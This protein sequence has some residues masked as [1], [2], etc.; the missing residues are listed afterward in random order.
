[1]R[2]L[3]GGTDKGRQRKANQDAFICGKISD[4][5]VYCVL[6]D[7]MGG[8]NGGGIASETAISYVSGA[9]ARELKEGMSELSVKSVLESA[10]A[11]ANALIYEHA[12]Q[13]KSLSGMGTTMIIAV[14]ESNNVYIAFV[15]DSRVYISSGNACRQVTKDHTVVQMLVDIGEISEEDA[16][17]H[18][19]RHF[20]TRA[21]GVAKDVDMDFLTEKLAD[22]ESVLLCSDGL[23]TYLYEPGEDANALI[24]ECIEKSK[25]DSL[26]SFANAKGGSDNITAIIIAPTENKTLLN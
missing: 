4:D 5:M 24:D 19:K 3:F 26:I 10:F 25:V 13:D 18:P 7:G 2:K 17:V 20:I 14:V 9:L 21:V 12:Q 8:E 15:G 16:R 22:T 1:M 11:G 23:H 6:C